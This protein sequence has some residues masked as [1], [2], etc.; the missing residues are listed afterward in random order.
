[1]AM[2]APRRLTT[3][4]T[5]QVFVQHEATFEV[6]GL[7]RATSRREFDDRLTRLR[8]RNDTGARTLKLAV[9]KKLFERSG[10]LP[11]AKFP[12]QRLARAIVEMA[13]F[14]QAYLT[15][16]LSLARKPA[17][18]DRMACTLFVVTM[19]DEM[20]RSESS[21]A[22]RKIALNVCRKWRQKDLRTTAKLVRERR[23]VRGEPD[24]A[25]VADWFERWRHEHA[26]NALVRIARSWITPTERQRDD[27]TNRQKRR[28]GHNGP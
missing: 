7:M 16:I 17:Q 1:M 5:D 23:S 24:W 19:V 14:R 15:Y 28:G 27:S 12:A 8:K 9:A 18:P 6:D 25:G 11:V 26:G 20:N 21:T 4:I 13:E 10:A 3:N 2:T 22:M